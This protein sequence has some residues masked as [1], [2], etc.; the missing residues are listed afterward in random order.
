MQL[1]SG[2]AFAAIF[3]E[4]ESPRQWTSVQ[5]I[6]SRS[7]I[8]ATTPPRYHL[9][10]SPSYCISPTTRSVSS[11]SILRNKHHVSFH[12]P[13]L[14]TPSTSH[15][16]YVHTHIL[17]PEQIPHAERYKT[18]VHERHES[19][20]RGPAEISPAVLVECCRMCY[21]KGHL[22]SGVWFTVVLLE[23]WVGPQNCGVSVSRGG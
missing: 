17:T 22:E 20:S 14:P 15:K 3:C 10:A 23:G 19:G 4:Q 1:H 6:P 5:P 8:Q 13:P 9:S 18:S 12:P 21:R 7:C 11:Y 16:S 2:S